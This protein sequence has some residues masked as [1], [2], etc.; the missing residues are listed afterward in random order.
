MFG[1]PVRN[2]K[3]WEVCNLNE[4][5]SLDRGVSKARPRNSPE[6]LGGIYPLIQTGDV[7]NS[8]IYITAYKQT[9][10]ELGL[11]QSKLWP[12]GTMLITI[13]ANIA[14]H[15]SNSKPNLPKS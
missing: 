8:G 5:G 7:T 10:S 15:P 2:E 12:K 14:F 11:K 1:D 13:A 9:Y 4:L 6:L 3:G